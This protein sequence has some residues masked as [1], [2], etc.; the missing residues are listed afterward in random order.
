MLERYRWQ[1]ALA[2]A[3]QPG[4]HQDVGVG[5]LLHRTDAVAIGGLD[6]PALLDAVDVVCR[7]AR[8]TSTLRAPDS[9]P[10]A[11]R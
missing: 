2:A 3:D 4:L 5:D 8:C 1:V 11:A 9:V 10:F 7:H 6:R